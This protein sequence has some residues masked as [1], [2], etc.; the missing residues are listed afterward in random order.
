MRMLPLLLT[1]AFLDTITARHQNR[2]SREPHTMQRGGSEN[3][4]PC[5]GCGGTN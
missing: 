5:D 4:H 3:S 2:T 1:S